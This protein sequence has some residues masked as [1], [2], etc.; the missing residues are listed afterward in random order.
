MKNR[1]D[2]ALPFTVKFREQTVGGRLPACDTVLERVQKLRLI[3][4]GA[5]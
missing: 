4:A 5:I 2:L 1:C 3:T